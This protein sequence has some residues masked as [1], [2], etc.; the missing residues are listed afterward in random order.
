MKKSVGIIA[1]IAAVLVVG[2]ILCMNNPDDEANVDDEFDDDEFDQYF[3][4]NDVD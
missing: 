2:I 4:Q 1:A 3:D